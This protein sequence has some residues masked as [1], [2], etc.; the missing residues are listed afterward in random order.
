MISSL[1]PLSTMLPLFQ[2]TSARVRKSMETCKVSIKLH[3]TT[4]VADRS[5]SCKAIRPLKSIR[6][7]STPFCRHPS[8]SLPIETHTVVSTQASKSLTSQTIKKKFLFKNNSST[9][10]VCATKT[11][12]QKKSKVKTECKI[13]GGTNKCPAKVKKKLTNTMSF[14]SCLKLSFYALECKSTK[15]DLSLK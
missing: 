15:V 7:A 14:K 12:L 9:H 1:R 5:N 3:C 4:H 11:T 2:A 8:I 6:N 10:L 13:K